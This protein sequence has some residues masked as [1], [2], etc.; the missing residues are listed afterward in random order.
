MGAAAGTV[1][2]LTACEGGASRAGNT[3]QS[4]DGELLSRSMQLF[5]DAPS[6]RV[7]AKA[8]VAFGSGVE[9]SVDR[10]KNC[11][12]D[13]QSGFFQVAVERGGRTWMK[14]SD[15]HLQKS[16]TKPNGKRLEKELRGKWLELGQEGRIRKSMVDLCALTPLRT[17]TD[18]LVKPGQRATREPETTEDGMR[19]VPVRWGEA[20][21]SVTAYLVAGEEPY[22]HKIV[23]DI[24]GFA[25]EPVDFWLADYGEPVRV[26]PPAA[27][28][29]VRS[30]AIEALAEQDLALGLPS[31]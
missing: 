30:A 7:A 14:W 8:A 2:A 23:V 11:R 19:I 21:N 22:P 18:Q 16:A 24:P 6:V 12:V 4:T 13:A 15:D 29:T 17:V 9:I 10:D 27:S 20:G 28:Q 5:R 25:L 31:R 26:E 1:L 3:K